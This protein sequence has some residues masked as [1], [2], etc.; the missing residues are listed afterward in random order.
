MRSYNM[1]QWLVFLL[2]CLHC[3]RSDEK[4]FLSNL[5]QKAGQKIQKAVSFFQKSTPVSTWIN[6]VR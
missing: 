1:S 6:Y 2:I 5:I 3:G 4:P